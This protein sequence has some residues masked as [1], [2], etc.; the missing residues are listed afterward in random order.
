MPS[1]PQGGADSD[2]DQWHEE[3]GEEAQLPPLAGLPALRGLHVHGFA[4][5]PPDWR[6]LSSLRELSV[7]PLFPDDRPTPEA[8]SFDQPVDALTAVTRLRLPAAHLTP[9]L[10]QLEGL[11]ELTILCG[12]TALPPEATRLSNLTR[13]QLHEQQAGAVGDPTLPPGQL[14]SALRHLIIAC[15][16]SRRDAWRVVLSAP[17]ASA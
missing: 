7:R 2:N 15:P 10:C 12:R 4:V 17:G 16:V 5:L 1:L 8:H 14:L 6:Q 9:A 3:L 11:R 13:L